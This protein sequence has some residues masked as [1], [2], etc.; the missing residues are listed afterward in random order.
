MGRLSPEKGVWTLVQAFAGL[1]Q[2]R[3]EIIGEGPLRG[4]LEAFLHTRG[5]THIHLHG[6]IESDRRFDIL[7]NAA[8]LV[9]PSEWYENC[10]YSLLESMALGVP[11]L[12]A[13]MG[14]VGEIVEEGVTGDL[15]EAGDTEE[16]RKKMESL[17]ADPERL[18]S[19]RKAARDAA[20]ARFHPERAYKDLM[21]IQG[22]MGIHSD[23]RDSDE[24]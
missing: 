11:V 1:T 3:L 6:F 23:G 15:F 18:A 20:L 24:S 10:P 16:L 14:G 4:K 21:A 19:M 22:R 2:N 13:R 8:F 17:W 7:R 5:L 12:A 9:F